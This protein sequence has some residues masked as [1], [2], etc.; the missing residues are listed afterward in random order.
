[1]PSVLLLA[2]ARAA[3]GR[4]RGACSDAGCGMWSAPRLVRSTGCD[5]AVRRASRGAS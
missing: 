1:L 5:G 2:A 3:A 4:R